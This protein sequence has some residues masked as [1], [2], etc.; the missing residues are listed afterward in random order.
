[1]ADYL[2]SKPQGEYATWKLHFALFNSRKRFR[3]ELGNKD[4]L[5]RLRQTGRH[6]ARLGPLEGP[7]ARHKKEKRSAWNWRIRTVCSGATAT[8]PSS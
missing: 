4:D 1:M 2:A 7:M 5:Q 3:L 8:R 6:P